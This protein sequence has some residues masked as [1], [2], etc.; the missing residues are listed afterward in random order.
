MTTYLQNRTDTW[1]GV[2]TLIPEQDLAAFLLAVTKMRQN[3]RLLSDEELSAYRRWYV[4]GESQAFDYFGETLSEAELEWLISM[5][6]T[7]EAVNTPLLTD[8]LANIAG[9]FHGLG[10]QAY[11]PH[12]ISAFN[13]DFEVLLA[14]EA[15]LRRHHTF[16]TPREA[17]I[18]RRWYVADEV[19]QAV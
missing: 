12:L 13:T 1:Q 17:D 14:V 6:K 16:L 15:K 11:Q 19:R 10:G 7:V 2:L 3:E 9:E 18:Y 4:Q 5:E 8:R